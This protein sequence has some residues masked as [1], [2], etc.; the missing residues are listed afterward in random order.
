MDL[1]FSASRIID[2][3][4]IF[5]II[6]KTF[7]DQNDYNT[8]CNSLTYKNVDEVVNEISNGNFVIVEYD[9]CPIGCVKHKI[10]TDHANQLKCCYLGPLA[11]VPEYQDACVENVILEFVI[12]VAIT[13]RCTHI[14]VEILNS[15]LHLMDMFKN[16]GFRETDIYPYP[17]ARDVYVISMCKLLM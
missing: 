8:N 2:A 1:V 17:G 4:I 13:N 6:N 14:M 12:N 15:M 10:D 9:D 3:E 5:S 7:R 16:A 11:V